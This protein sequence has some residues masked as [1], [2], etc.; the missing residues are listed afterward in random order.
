MTWWFRA[1]LV[2]VVQRAL[3][4]CDSSFV[5]FNTSAAE[6]VATFRDS[7]NIL[8]GWNTTLMSTGET[9]R[10]VLGTIS[11]LPHLS[12]RIKRKGCTVYDHLKI[13]NH[14]ETTG[15]VHKHVG[16][17]EI[18]VFVEGPSIQALIANYK[19]C[20][21]YAVHFEIPVAGTYRLKVVHLRGNYSAFNETNEN[22]PEMLYD[23]LVERPVYFEKVLRTQAH[24]KAGVGGGPACGGHWVAR[25]SDQALYNESVLVYEDAQRKFLR[26]LPLH[27]WVRLSTTAPLRDVNGRKATCADDTNNFDWVVSNTSEAAA[28][29]TPT[30]A[31]QI[32]TGKRILFIGD[33]HTRTLMTHFMRWAC[34]VNFPVVKH[35]NTQISIPDTASRCAGLHASYVVEY[36]CATRTLPALK[37]HDFVMVNCGHHPAA[38]LG[39]YP[40]KDYKEIVRNLLDTAVSKGFNNSNFA[41]LE[42]VPQ[43]LRYD[44]WFR[45]YRDWRSYHR[46]N[47]Y[48]YEANK[49]VTKANFSIVHA[50]S[51][52][53]PFIDK[54]CDNAHYA[55]PEALMP[56][57]QRILQRIKVA[58]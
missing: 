11:S 8:T 39:R 34:G 41:W 36:F 17:D 15:L 26:G 53:M 27:S 21:T 49:L 3:S 45:G 12:I 40:L 37:A 47:V 9:A 35:I 19:G 14:A 4:N 43:P 52:L 44:E 30:A 38:G 46:L 58:S 55:V 57:Y 25:Q 10:V 16:P 29:L 56:Q 20:N 23:V 28:V 24:G 5:T 18:I 32:M 6:P 31:G 54:L 51:A 1:L 2:L 48:N 50:F 33:S 7:S 42:S 22:T 13:S